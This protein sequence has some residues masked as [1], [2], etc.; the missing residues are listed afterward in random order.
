MDFI[1]EELERRAK[2]KNI[3]K[4]RFQILVWI[5]VIGLAGLYVAQYLVYERSRAEEIPR[6]SA[7]D[8]TDTH[9]VPTTPVDKTKGTSTLSISRFYSGPF[10]PGSADCSPSGTAYNSWTTENGL[11]ITASTVIDASLPVHT[12][13][14]VEGGHDLRPLSSTLIRRYGSNEDLALARSK[15]IALLLSGPPSGPDDHASRVLSTIRAPEKNNA[16][17]DRRT[18]VTIVAFASA[19]P[20]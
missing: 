8:T 15:C 14:I 18:K 9:A 7:A 11:P 13:I 12:F 3:A 16:D 2:E 4:R 19:T 6:P 20:L 1:E 5:I 17:D 10:V